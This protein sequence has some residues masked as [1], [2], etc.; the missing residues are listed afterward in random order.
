MNKTI[1]ELSSLSE[2]EA[3]DE[4]L[5]YDVSSN[6]SKKIAVKDIAGNYSETETLTGATWIDGKPIY[7]RVFTFTTPLTIQPNSWT[8]TNVSKTGFDSLISVVAY[9]ETKTCWNA[10]TINFGTTYL[11]LLHSRSGAITV[12]NFV[13]EYTK[14]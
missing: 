8:D 1:H 14:S 6:E 4:M 10:M 7:R 13:L 5:V 12:K 9:S 3:T 11:Q 2:A